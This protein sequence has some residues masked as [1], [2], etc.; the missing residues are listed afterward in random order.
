MSCERWCAAVSRP[1]RQCYHQQVTA[2]VV[3]GR[4]VGP[5]PG[6][7]PAMYW[8][9][10][11]RWPNVW[12]LAG[13]AAC[14]PA[15]PCLLLHVCL[16][17]CQSGWLVGKHRLS[18]RLL[19]LCMLLNIVVSVCM[20]A[21]RLGVVYSVLSSLIGCSNHVTTGCLPHLHIMSLNHVILQ[22]LRS[23]EHSKSTSWTSHILHPYFI[24]C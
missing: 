6:R 22:T 23:W 14:L 10:S 13:C 5:G 9:R 8:Y 19:V 15:C 21:C 4:P 12:L 18:C 1:W 11:A 16:S 3:A 2:C 17:V 7:G 20:P 24:T